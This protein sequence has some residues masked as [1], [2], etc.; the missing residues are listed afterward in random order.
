MWDKLT[1]QLAYRKSYQMRQKMR[2]NDPNCCLTLMKYINLHLPTLKE[3]KNAKKVKWDRPTDRQTDIV[4]YWVA[5]TRLKTCTLLYRCKNASQKILSFSSNLL[6]CWFV[7]LANE[8][9]HCKESRIA[10]QR[11][12]G[13]SK[14]SDGKLAWTL[15]NSVWRAMKKRPY[16]ATDRQGDINAHVP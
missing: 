12:Q 4:T 1:D 5:C 11:Q 2:K 6:G 8:T 14:I 16:R 10:T 15:S 7:I 3:P 13:Y 9:S